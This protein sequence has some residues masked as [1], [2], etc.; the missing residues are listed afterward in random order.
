VRDWVVRT[1][2]DPTA[3]APATRSV[4]WIVDSALPITRVQTMERV[5]STSTAREQFT[6]LLVALFALLA[7]VLAAVGL[8]GVTAFAVAQRTHEL[9]I[10]VALGATPFDVVRLVVGLG[11]RLVLGGL[12]I[13]TIVAL[14]LS[15]LM[16]AML[17]GTS[18]RDPM[19]F[20]GVAALLTAV[21]LVACYLPARRAA[22]A[23][24][25]VALRT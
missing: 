11:G 7:L 24:P 21:S 12:V 16:G 19:T 18:A 14:G 1:A 8:Y 2:G 5:R 25:L 6:L 3:L 20:A 4:V 9:G 23:D 10:R 13:G 15:Q 17:F 22:R